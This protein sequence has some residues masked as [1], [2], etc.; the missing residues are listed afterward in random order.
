MLTCERLLAIT[1]VYERVPYSCV[2][3]YGLVK[4]DEL[5]VRAGVGVN[6]VGC[7]ETAIAGWKVAISPICKGRCFESNRN[8]QP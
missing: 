8:H 1:Q 2:H 4:P 5:P 7:L 3:T 6:Q